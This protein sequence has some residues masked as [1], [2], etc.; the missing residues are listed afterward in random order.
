LPGTRLARAKQEITE[1]HSAGAFH[2]YEIRDAGDH[3]VGVATHVDTA[4]IGGARIRAAG[5][6]RS[7]ANLIKFAPTEVS[8]GSAITTSG[9]S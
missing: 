8:A 6:A 1:V 5:R 4:C 9:R 3:R 7:N 2:Y